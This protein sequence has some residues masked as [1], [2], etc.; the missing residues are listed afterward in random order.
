MAIATDPET[1]KNA[2]DSYA[3]MREA[4]VAF[5]QAGF[6]LVSATL[7]RYV[8]DGRLRGFRDRRGVRWI[9]RSEIALLLSELTEKRQQ[10]HGSEHARRAE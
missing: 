2:L 6:P 7:R 5:I 4:E 10:D 8:D 3:G 1:V 9:L